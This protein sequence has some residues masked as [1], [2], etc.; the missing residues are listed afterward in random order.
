[1]CE[2]SV[3]YWF[4]SRHVVQHMQYFLPFS[5]SA[6]K[7]N[8]DNLDLGFANKCL[9]VHQLQ[10]GSEETASALKIWR[11]PSCHIWLS[12]AKQLDLS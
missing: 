2:E 11:V 9:T 1:M 8:K 3:G 12:L 4:K 7:Q 10:A 5:L 6:M